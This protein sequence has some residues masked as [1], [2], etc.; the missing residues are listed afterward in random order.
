MPG[1]PV[2]SRVEQKGNRSEKEQTASDDHPEI[3]HAC[4]ILDRWAGLLSEKT[5]DE[6]CT[7]LKRH[8]GRHQKQH[9]GD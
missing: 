1:L 3:C 8:D 5:T 9:S 4:G 6:F 7:A 2:P